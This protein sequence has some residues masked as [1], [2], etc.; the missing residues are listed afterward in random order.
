MVVS[1]L[2]LVVLSPLF[3]VVELLIRL[4]T[5]GPAIFR[6]ERVGYDPRTGTLKM[7]TMYK[8]RS[9]LHNC[10]QELHKKHIQDWVRGQ[11]AIEEG[12]ESSAQMKLAN[13]PRVTRV[14]AFIRKT[15]IDE[16]PQLYNVL[17]GDM[18]LVG[19]RPVPIYEVQ[20]YQPR[21][22]GRLAAKPGIT[23]LWQVYGRGQVGVDQ[24]ADMDI[25]YIERQSLWLDLKLLLKTIPVVLSKR[26]A[27]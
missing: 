16:L 26:G 14:G 18:S 1:A 12:S 17:Q 21:H 24:M 22:Y 9:M 5:P 15:S 23:C 20:E 6:Q 25:E 19:P 7:F 3:L 2:A 4:D 13:D 11:A 8:F 10:D 27:A